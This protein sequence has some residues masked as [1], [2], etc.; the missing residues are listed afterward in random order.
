M[1]KLAIRN[2]LNAT[3]TGKGAVTRKNAF[4]AIAPH[5]YSEGL[6]RAELVATIRNA[7]GK[8]PTPADVKL[9]K[10]EYVIGRIA[11]RLA[12]AEF[13]KG[14]FDSVAKVGKAREW[15]ELYAAPVQDGKA[16]RKLRKGQ[17]GRRPI[18]VQRA[19][20]AAEEAWSQLLAECGHGKAQT[21]GERNAKKRAPAMAGST[22]RGKGATPVHSDLIQPAKAPTA[23]DACQHVTLQA[24]S[25]LAFANKNAA[26]LPT[27]FG[28]AIK[29]FK[30]AIDKAD[31]ERR[32]K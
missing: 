14:T 21:Q 11:A 18:A 29:A 28:T 10:S 12:P 25:L 17:L 22:A 1:T 5:A 20:R 2:A 13:G 16:A 26:L 19:I 8:S 4:I 30:K 9:A 27:D 6:S 3:F 31:G 23:D 15:V 7:L 32:L 24:A